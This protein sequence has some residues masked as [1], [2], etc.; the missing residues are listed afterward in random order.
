M[1]SLEKL[2]GRSINTC[3]VFSSDFWSFVAQKIKFPYLSGTKHQELHVWMRYVNLSSCTRITSSL[4]SIITYLIRSS[5]SSGF[6]ISTTLFLIISNSSV[7][8]CS[9]I[10]RSFPSKWIYKIF[11]TS[12]WYYLQVNTASILID[13]IRILLLR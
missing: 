10:W 7:C 8:D 4:C 11:P 6:M 2:L 5:T 12:D 9:E 13:G 3:F 1:H